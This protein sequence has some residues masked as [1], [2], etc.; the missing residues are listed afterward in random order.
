MALK[1]SGFSGVDVDIRGDSETSKEPVSLLVSTKSLNSRPKPATEFALIGTGG[2]LTTELCFKIQ[3]A[4]EFH[5]LKPSLLHWDK[6]SEDDIAG[7]YCICLA[8]WEEPILAYVSDEN[9]E[10]LRRLVLTAKGTLWVTGGAA[11]ECLRPFGSLM[12]GLSRAVRN[13]NANVLLATLDTD[14]PGSANMDISSA[15]IHGVAI[16]HS[17]GD[18]SDHEYATRNGIV[19]VPRVTKAPSLNKQL[20]EYE[21]SGEPE[22]V[23]F[24]GCGRPLKLTIKTPGL[25]DSFRFDEDEIYYQP[26]PE[27]WIEIKV[28]AVGLNFKDVLVAMANLNEDKLGV[29]V[30]GV[31]NRVGT[32]VTDIKPGDRVMTSSCNTFATFVRFPALGAIAIP[33]SMSFEDAASMPLIYLTAFYALVTVG[34]LV[35]GESVLIHAAAGGVGQAAI[36]IAQF[37]GAEIFAT[38]GSEEKKQLIMKE[39]EIPDDHIFSSRDLSF[40]K[41]VMRATNGVGVGEFRATLDT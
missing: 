30:S 18:S 27:D 40:A 26:M 38:V 13:E 37:V 7:K 31:V 23:S 2:A 36:V 1:K 14:E 34:R 9:W 29:D 6:F 32:A 28:K 3:T 10:R 25:L 4:F 22:E 15:A 24:N 33:E 39:Y 16:S 11:M 12:A 5:S 8:E 41:A 21:S 19:Y 35:Q 17:R 20:R